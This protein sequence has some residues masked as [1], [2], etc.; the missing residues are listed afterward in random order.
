M[1]TGAE[2]RYRVTISV[3]WV[4]AGRGLLKVFPTGWHWKMF[5][6]VKANPVALTTTRHTIDALRKKT[7]DFVKWI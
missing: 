1:F 4:V 3:H 7:C 2:L 6:I 5:N